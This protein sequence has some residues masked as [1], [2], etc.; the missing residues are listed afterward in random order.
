M[1]KR[2][3]VDIKAET[4]SAFVLNVEKKRKILC[5]TKQKIQE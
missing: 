2:E 1:G 3:G 5:Q 4:Q